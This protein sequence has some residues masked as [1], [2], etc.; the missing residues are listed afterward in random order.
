MD[1]FDKK[2][3]SDQHK[4]LFNKV[5][6]LSLDFANLF[7]RMDKRYSLKWVEKG[8]I[9]VICLVTAGIVGALIKGVIIDSVKAIF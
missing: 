4:E 6:G 7:E 8:W 2:S 1:D 5:Q 3:N 9:Y